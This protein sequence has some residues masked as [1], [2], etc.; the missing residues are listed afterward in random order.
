[1]TPNEAKT[2]WCPFVR[3]VPAS[4]DWAFNRDKAVDPEL[5]N[6]IGPDCAV[7]RWNGD[8]PVCRTWRPENLTRGADEPPRP[9]G[10]PASWE[11]VS[12]EE[13][14]APCWREPVAEA[15]ARRPGYCGLA[16]KDGAP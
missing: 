3:V 2:K 16:G 5:R 4:H 13:D 12:T 9:E 1:M 8:P 15:D 11:W 7:W 6:C 10:L 14:L